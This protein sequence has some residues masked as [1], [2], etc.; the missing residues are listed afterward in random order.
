M[1]KCTFC[2]EEILKGS[3]IMSVKNDGTVSYYCGSKCE[4]NAGMRDPRF[5]KWT[6]AFRAGKQAAKK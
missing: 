4:R 5:V 1:V 2:K 6:G 3:G